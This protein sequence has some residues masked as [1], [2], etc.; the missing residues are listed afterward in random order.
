MCWR[1]IPATGCSFFRGESDP[2]R[3][4]GGASLPWLGP[5]VPPHAS[6]AIPTCPSDP[7]GPHRDIQPRAG[8]PATHSFLQRTGHTW[9][10]TSLDSLAGCAVQEP[11]T[12]RRPTLMLGCPE[13]TS[14]PPLPTCCGRQQAGTS[15]CLRLPTRTRGS[16]G[17]VGGTPHSPPPRRPVV[18]RWC[19]IPAVGARGYRYRMVGAV[20]TPRGHTRLSHDGFTWRAWME[21]TLTVQQAPGQ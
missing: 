6:R 21:G 14:A 11:C 13:R 20:A 17:S 7:L 15:S 19:A 1:P 12:S 2:L 10:A 3:S 8:W 16:R 9:Q 18:V 5:A 4:T